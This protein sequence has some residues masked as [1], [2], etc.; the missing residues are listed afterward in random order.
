MPELDQLLD[1]A[2]ALLDRLE[3]LVPST[4]PAPVP[5]GAAVSW[6]VEGLRR[7]FCAVTTT[8]DTSLSD[9][10]CIERQKA[11]LD[12]NTRQFLSGLPAN[13]ALLWGPRGTGKSSLIRALFAEYQDRGLRLAEVAREELHCLPAICAALAAAPGRFLLYCDDLSFSSGDDSYRALKP[14]VDGSVSSLPDNVLI[15]ATS[16]RRHLLPEHMEDNLESR[17]VDGE[18]HTGEAVEDKLS[19]SERFGLRISFHPFTQDQYLQIVAHWI[20]R[21]DPRAEGDAEEI[22][23][24]ALQWALDH[25]SRSGRSAWQFSRDWVGQAGLQ[26]A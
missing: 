3:R 7:G 2:H 16:N 13:H 25:G 24:A 11:L 14:M 17:L 26:I 5:E 9:L 12:R 23:R 10:Q 22:R 1:R 4:A 15:Y 21:L 18:L 6:H 20:R 8:V 19:L